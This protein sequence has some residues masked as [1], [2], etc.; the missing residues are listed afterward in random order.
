MEQGVDTKE[1]VKEHV[2]LQRKYEMLKQRTS[3]KIYK[4][5]NELK[6]KTRDL[7]ESLD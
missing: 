2:E 7:K 6:K 1:I 3:K 4:L 5:E